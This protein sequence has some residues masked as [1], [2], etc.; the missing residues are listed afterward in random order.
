MLARKNEGTAIKPKYF[1]D[2]IE[3]KV[4]APTFHQPELLYAHQP[5]IRDLRTA[6]HK[7]RGRYRQP[8]P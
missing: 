8:P 2:W 7:R 1:I 4:V 5:D 6:S 3:T